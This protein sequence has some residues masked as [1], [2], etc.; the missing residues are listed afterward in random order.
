LSRKLSVVSCTIWE[1]DGEY[2]HMGPEEDADDD[3]RRRI[4]WELDERCA[5]RLESIVPD[6]RARRARVDG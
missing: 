4:R 1:P 2:S 6:H 3:Y 5:W